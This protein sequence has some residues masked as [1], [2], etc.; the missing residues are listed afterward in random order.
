MGMGGVVRNLKSTVAAHS[1][2]AAS[3]WVRVR[4]PSAEQGGR[5]IQTSFTTT[6]SAGSL[7]VAAPK[8]RLVP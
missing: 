6:H 8:G 5:E 1:G 4:A 3:T 2:E 7:K